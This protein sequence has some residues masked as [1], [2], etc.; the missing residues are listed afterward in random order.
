MTLG[1]TL[2]AGNT[3]LGGDLGRATGVFVSSGNNLIGSTAGSITT[4]W[5]ELRP[6]RHTVANPLLPV[7]AALGNY[8]GPTQTMPLLPGS[9]A[10][11]K[12]SNALIPGGVTTDQRGD[13]RIVNGNVDI[14]AVESQG[15]TLTVTGGNSQTTNA[16]T[17]FSSP[18]AV[19]V[20]PI[21]ASD[22]VNGGVVTFAA[23]GSGASL[24]P[25]TTS[26]TIA[27]GSASVTA[28]ANN[29]VGTFNV[30]ASAS[31]AAAPASFSLTNVSQL[32]VNNPTDTP[33]AGQTDLRQAI[34]LANAIAGAN[35]ITFDATVFA[36]PQTII[37][38]GTQLLLTNTTGT[39]TIT[40]PAAG[41]TVSGNHA[42]RVFQVNPSVTASISGLTIS[43][44]T[45]TGIGGG[46]YNKGT[47][48]LT[49][50]TLSGNTASAQR[51]RPVQHQH[52]DASRLHRQRQHRR[53]R[54]G[55]IVGIA[56]AR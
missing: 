15:Y 54:G 11:D 48:T 7:I 28:T 2:V 26:A 25:A 3:A 27:G 49:N 41:V 39:E 46:V 5:I 13:S 4:A 56:A 17:A 47:V 24:T 53:G 6:D 29:T 40:G 32:V 18:L 37:L 44:G 30:S 51:R 14:G 55:G 12:G 8:G 33:V 22:P 23:P 43:G 10:I 9:P 1:N 34:A 52:G 31:G 16:T 21:N 19:S 50:V 45:V 38:G 36:T 20:T 35:T 42:S